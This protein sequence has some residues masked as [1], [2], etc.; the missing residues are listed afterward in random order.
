MAGQLVG[1]LRDRMVMESVLRLVQQSLDGDGWFDSGR[2]HQPI[3]IVDEYPD[4]DTEV[5]INTLAFS[6][7]D[8]YQRMVEL[9][10]RAELF[11][12]PIYIDFFAE[13][14]GLSR[15]IIGDIYAWANENP[16]IPVWNFDMA[17]PE[18]D[19]YIEIM[20][21]SVEVQR[22][23]RATHP[24]LKHWATLVFIV[25]DQRENA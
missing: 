9:G 10:H 14:D 8:T 11:H 15:H 24:W 3:T 23:T 16:V 1:G 5:P 19:F 18:V 22:A 2:N 13:S 6:F 4:T 17:T 21:E 25:S 12:V 20:E 7:G